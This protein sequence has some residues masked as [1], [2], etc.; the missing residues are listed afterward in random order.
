MNKDLIIKLLQSGKLMLGISLAFSTIWGLDWAFSP[1]KWT[2]AIDVLLALLNGLVL[3][4]SGY[5]TLMEKRRK[6]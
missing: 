1:E 4:S 3:A 5:L 6:R 2:Q